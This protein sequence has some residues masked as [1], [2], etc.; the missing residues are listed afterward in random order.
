MTVSQLVSPCEKAA[1]GFDRRLG[2]NGL[3]DSGLDTLDSNISKEVVRDECMWLHQQNIFCFLIR[4]FGL[5]GALAGA[6]QCCPYHLGCWKCCLALSG[7]GRA[8]Q[9][10]LMC[11]MPWVNALNELAEM[12]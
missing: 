2:S 11:Q 6:S 4:Y 7:T 9:V 5:L 8:T 10:L 3:S 1:R 12:L